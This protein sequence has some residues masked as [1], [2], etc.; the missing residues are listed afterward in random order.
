MHNYAKYFFKLAHFDVYQRKK[1]NP[2]TL[3]VKILT[4]ICQCLFV[5]T[6][7]NVFGFAKYYFDQ[8]SKSYNNCKYFRL[9]AHRFGHYEVIFCQGCFHNFSPAIFN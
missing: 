9:F 2:N 4:N 5:C 6:E 3:S 1:W 7:P 8:K